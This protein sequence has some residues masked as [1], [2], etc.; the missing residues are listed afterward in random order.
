[1]YKLI[2][3]ISLFLL[4]ILSYGSYSYLTIENPTIESP[5]MESPAMESEEIEIIY[6]IM[7]AEN[8]IY[9]Y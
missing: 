2:I 1:M 3:V 9:S 6:I 7:S 8:I 4:P 5:A